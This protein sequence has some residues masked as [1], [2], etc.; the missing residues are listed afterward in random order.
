[1]SKFESD[2]CKIL[3]LW[4]LYEGTN[5]SRPHKRLWIF[6]ICRAISPLPWAVL[7]SN[8]ASLVI[9][10]RSF[11]QCRRILLTDPY[12]LETIPRGRVYWKRVNRPPPPPKK[13]LIK[14]Q[15]LHLMLCIL[16]LSSFPNTVMESCKLFWR[17]ALSIKWWCLIVSF[18]ICFSCSGKQ[19][20]YVCLSSFSLRTEIQSITFILRGA[21]VQ[22]WEAIM[23][24]I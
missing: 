20:K 22:I 5:L 14:V 19:R 1:M 10:W 3:W 17:F 15:K 4:T 9:L 21:T 11:Q 2:L 12:Q 13:R 18:W 23:L 6:A 8:L 7:L 16:L 24:T